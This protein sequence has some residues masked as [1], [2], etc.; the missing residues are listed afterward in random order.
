MPADRPTAEVDESAAANPAGPA[1]ASS[2]G[3]AWNIS[4]WI[5]DSADGEMAADVEAKLPGPPQCP[6]NSWRAEARRHREV[7]VVSCLA[8]AAAFAMVEVPGGRVAF[9]GFTNYPLP[10]ACASRAIFGWKCAG[11]GLTRSV[12]HLAEGDWRS[13]WRSHRLGMLMAAAIVLQVPYRLLALRRP[14]RPP[15]PAGW[16]SAAGLALIALLL[17]NWL[18][19]VVTAR[20]GSV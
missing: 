4:E 5:E 12:I 15:I 1:C 18:V 9:R 6:P 17:L 13:S 10:H 19:E 3:A 16:M 2:S 8:I 7:L 11:C 20:V 14:G